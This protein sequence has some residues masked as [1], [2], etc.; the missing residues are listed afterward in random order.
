[1]IGVTFP[2]FI[3]EAKV[4]EMIQ[5]DDE[6]EQLIETLNEMKLLSKY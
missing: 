4:V 5:V 6:Y 1:M 3:V 2:E